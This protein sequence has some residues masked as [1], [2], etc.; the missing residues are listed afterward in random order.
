MKVI[1]CSRR[2]PCF[3]VQITLVI[4]SGINLNTF[5]THLAPFQ[6][7]ATQHCDKSVFAQC[8]IMT[9]QQ[10]P[11]FHLASNHSLHCGSVEARVTEVFLRYYPFPGSPNDTRDQ[12][13]TGPWH[14]YAVAHAHFGP[15][16]V[17]MTVKQNTED[18]IS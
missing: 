4:I 14:V 9:C 12:P 13:T 10:C 8:V 18:V 11:T 3:H 16:V 5:H 15:V 2:F 1:K 17:A 7:P 6:N